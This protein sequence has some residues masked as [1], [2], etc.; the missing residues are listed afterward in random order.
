MAL[1]I[2]KDAYREQ[3]KNVSAY[4]LIKHLPGL[5]EECPWVA[6]VDSQ[7]LTASILRMDAAYKKFFAGGGFPKFKNRRGKQSFAAPCNK[8]EVDFE[9][10]TLSIPKLK[11][12]PIVIS[13]RFKG[14]I[15]TVTI[16][17]V[18]S[19]KYFASI[20]VDNHIPLPKKQTIDPNKTIG[21]DLGLK[22]FAITSDG[23]KFSNPKYLKEA[24]DRLKCLQRRASR[25]KKGSSNRRKA[26][27]RLAIQ[28]ERVANKRKDFLHKL[29]TGLVNDSQVTTI[30]IEDLAVKNMVKNQKLAQAISDVG[31][32][33]LRRML[34]YKC[35]WSG[36]NLV[37][38]G[39]FEPSS[40]TCSK[41]QAINDTLTLNDRDWVCASC[42]ALHDRDINAAENIKQFGLNN[43]GRGTPGEPVESRTLVWAKKQEYKKLTLEKGK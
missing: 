17:R 38:I 23:R 25:K 18:P 37:V 27:K 21:I 15:K 43:S 10:Q 19:G 4:D 20:L 6:E 29:S 13:K 31:W 5:K 42:G 16:T 9:N 28:H 41:C 2:K 22:D 34:Q 33:E 7:A 26:N 11:D 35:D 1:R 40:K 30:C 3:Q 24:L 36:K 14:D 12:I 39:R 32:A 8:R